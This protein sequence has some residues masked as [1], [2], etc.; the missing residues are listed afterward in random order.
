MLDFPRHQ[1]VTS[2]TEVWTATVLTATFSRIGMRRRNGEQHTRLFHP[3]SPARSVAR[4]IAGC[5]TGV[6]QKPLKVDAADA[7]YSA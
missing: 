4:P 6:G 5:D 1:P 3:L 2:C 7:G